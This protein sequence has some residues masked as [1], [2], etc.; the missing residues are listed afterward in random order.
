[1]NTPSIIA[2][3]SEWL[4]VVAVSWLLI[5]QPA[6]LAARQVGFLYARRDGLAA[7][8]ISFIVILFSVLF[9]TTGMGDTLTSLVHLPGAAAVLNRSAG[10]WR[11]FR[12]CR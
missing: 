5:A 12:S 2:Q 10:N 11:F 6:L 8:T 3:I 9:Y 7:V 1:M 4:G